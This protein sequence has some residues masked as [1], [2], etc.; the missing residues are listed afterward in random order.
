MCPL[1]RQLQYL[2]IN[3]QQFSER[4]KKWT[5]T[6]PNR[7]IILINPC[8][9]K[10]RKDV[11]LNQSTFTNLAKF[12]EDNLLQHNS[13]TCAFLLAF[14]ILAIFFAYQF[15]VRNQLFSPSTLP[16][17]HNFANSSRNRFSALRLEFKFYEYMN[18]I[19]CVF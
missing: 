3:I 12:M 10:Y 4:W 9:K 8:L 14:T 13:F 18:W 17:L 5:Y 19:L 6:V 15:S 11:S 16:W 7:N 2:I 1:L